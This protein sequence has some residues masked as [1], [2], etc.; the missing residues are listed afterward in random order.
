MFSQRKMSKGL[1]CVSAAMYRGATG[2]Q[3]TERN[4]GQHLKPY[5]GS[6]CR[7]WQSSPTH[8][9]CNWER[10]TRHNTG[11]QKAGRQHQANC[12]STCQFG[13]CC[14]RKWQSQEEK[15]GGSTSQHMSTCRG[16]RWRTDWRWKARARARCGPNKSHNNHH[17]RLNPRWDREEGQ[18]PSQRTPKHSGRP[19]AW[20]PWIVM[21]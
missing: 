6:G 8:S 4:F 11:S 20:Y 17:L 5:R 9:T 18:G 14:S 12:R 1:K 15:S 7:N 16:I 2:K 21:K 3:T 10:P 13:K 19:W